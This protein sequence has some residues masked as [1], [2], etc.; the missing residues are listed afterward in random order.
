MESTIP[1]LIIP[2]VPQAFL[3]L[4]KL[5]VEVPIKPESHLSR[6]STLYSPTA[7]DFDK[8]KDK[9]DHARLTKN[10]ADAY[11]DTHG[12]RL[13]IKG[14]KLPFTAVMPLG[15]ANVDEQ[16]PFCPL[17]VAIGVEPKKVTYEDAKAVSESVKLT[18]LAEAGFDD[19]EVAI[20]EFETFLSSSGPKLLALDPELQGHLTEFYHAF[21]STLGIAVAPLKQPGYEGSLGLFLTRGDD[22]KLLALTAAHVARPPWMFPDNKGLSLKAADMHNEDIVM[23]GY[24]AN[25][26][27]VKKI[28]SEVGRL[29]QSIK[30]DEQRI[31][32]LQVRLNNG[33]E[34]ADGITTAIRTARQN[35]DMSKE[36]IR[37]LAIHHGR[38]T[39]LMPIP[40]NRCI[41]RVLF[42]DPIGASSDGPDAHTR[43]WAVLGIRKDAFGDDFQGNILYIGILYH[44]G[45]KLGGQAFLDRMFPHYADRD[46]YVYPEHGLLRFRGVVPMEGPLRPKQRDA[47]GDTALAVAKNSRT[48]GTTTGW[49]SELKSLVRYYKFINVEFT[50]R[51]LTIV[52]YDNKPGTG[53][54]SDRDDSGAAIVDRGG[55]VVALLTGG[56]GGGISDATDVTF[57]SPYCEV[58]KRMKEIFPGIRLLE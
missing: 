1:P 10:Y 6:S 56:G 31:V 44:A 7:P 16:E 13:C 9:V 18:I 53:A 39:G 57:A 5:N 22:S 33:A 19:V 25:T 20:W 35:V 43:D 49:Y 38:V 11:T 17:L 15:F 30:N 32:G 47:K 24:E 36:S 4:C 21:T 45:D 55:R 37:Q 8:L 12:L 42:A 26:L 46:G 40:D 28:Q 50:S 3:D 27:A 29:Q 54:F 58:E 52:P 14:A 48:T 23:L 2:G 41:A 51:E 34:D